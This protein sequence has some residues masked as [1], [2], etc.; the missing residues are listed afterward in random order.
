MSDWEWYVPSLTRPEEWE[1]AEP[2]EKGAVRFANCEP[3]R[4]RWSRQQTSGQYP[5]TP[6]PQTIPE[7]T[8]THVLGTD[9]EVYNTTGETAVVAV[10]HVA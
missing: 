8:W 10:R 2:H 3:L 6:P 9:V 4:W 7:A 5:R 1:T